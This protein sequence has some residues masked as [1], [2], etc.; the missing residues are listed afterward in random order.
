MG[1]LRAVPEVLL[2]RWREVVDYT[3]VDLGHTLGHGF[4]GL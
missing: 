2:S 1:A 4:C 3:D